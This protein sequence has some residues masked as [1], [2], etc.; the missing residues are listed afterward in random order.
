MP[1]EW[2]AYWHWVRKGLWL[3]LNVVPIVKN[4]PEMA[5]GLRLRNPKSLGPGEGLGQQSQR[6]E[7]SITHQTSFI[8]C[9]GVF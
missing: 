8:F 4:Y 9:L 2:D 1:G 5:A 3:L 7:L 6:G